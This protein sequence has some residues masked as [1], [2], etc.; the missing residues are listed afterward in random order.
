MYSP[1]SLVVGHEQSDPAIE[2]L[3]LNGVVGPEQ[4]EV[5]ALYGIAG[6]LIAVNAADC[7]LNK[8]IGQ[9][10]QSAIECLRIE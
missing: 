7:G 5:F 8:N 10:P 6:R 1:Y 2:H 9:N 4:L 3:D